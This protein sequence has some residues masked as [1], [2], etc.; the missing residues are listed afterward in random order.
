MVNGVGELPHRLENADGIAPPSIRV[1]VAG[2]PPNG[3]IHP[4]PREVRDDWSCGRPPRIITIL[5]IVEDVPRFEEN[6][7]MTRNGQA[8]ANGSHRFVFFGL[9]LLS[10]LIAVGAFSSPAS[11]GAS[12]PS[13]CFLDEGPSGDLPPSGHPCLPEYAESEIAA[14]AEVELED[15]TEYSWPSL[16]H[17]SPST[18]DRLIAESRPDRDGLHRFFIDAADLS[19]SCRLTL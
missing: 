13:Q 12:D 10:V 1:I 9:A 3:H 2:M 4:T 17:D 14:E 19:R 5:G 15:G 6:A 11:S 8:A 16:G 7:P 18:R